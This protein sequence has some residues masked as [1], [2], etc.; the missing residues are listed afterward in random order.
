MKEAMIT[1]VQGN[2][3]GVDGSCFCVFFSLLIFLNLPKKSSRFQ[4][5]KFLLVGNLY[6]Q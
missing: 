3:L 1:E 4:F 6:I 5:S 2:I